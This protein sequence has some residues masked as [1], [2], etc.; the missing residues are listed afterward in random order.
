MRL[1]D[2]AADA[3]RP[4][5]RA[6]ACAFEWLTRKRVPECAE[7]HEQLL[8]SL[9][10]S[11]A[12]SGMYAMWTFVLPGLTLYFTGAR[13]GAW[14]VLV[15]LVLNLALFRLQFLHSQAIRS[16]IRP[17]RQALLLTR[18]AWFL[19]LSISV[20]LSYREG[21]AVVVAMATGVA[22]GF[23]GYIWSRLAAFP[24]FAGL[25]FVMVWTSMTVG[26]YLVPNPEFG[27]LYLFVVPG[28]V[29][30]FVLLS[31]EHTKMLA[32]VRAQHEQ[33]RQATHDPLTGLANRTLVYERLGELCQVFASSRSPVRF[34][35]LA[36]DLDG[37][38]S[39]NDTLG[40]AAGDKLLQAIA[41]RLTSTVR[42]IDLVARM[43]GDE[44]IV[45]LSGAS[46]EQAKEAARRMLNGI[47][48]PFEAKAG[49]TLIPRGSVGIAAAPQDGAQ[50]DELMKSADRALYAA[51]AAGKGRWA[52]SQGEVEP[53]DALYRLPMPTPLA[54]VHGE[55]A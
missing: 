33:R 10:D 11:P 12:V 17:P 53:V 48:L 24:R 8:Q 41:T 18:V 22:M 6:T 7:V 5:Q 2:F 27:V 36:L 15:M 31:M 40:H 37:F 1:V 9:P 51:K 38:K 28:F 47:C 29:A 46:E 14:M 52:T 35:V 20:S 26:T 30:S 45:I 19:G 25:M 55:V 39:V 42:T 4:L 16:H 32:I 44:F 43:G 50:P 13:W 49:A 21:H 54:G 23:N 3:C 34:A